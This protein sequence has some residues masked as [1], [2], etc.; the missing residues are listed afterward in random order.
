MENDVSYGEFLKNELAQRHWNQAHLA[1]LIGKS[2]SVIGRIIHEQNKEPDPETCLAIARA[3]E[4]SPV[5]LMRIAKILP[6]EP[7]TIPLDH[8]RE[9]LGQLSSAGQTEVLKMAVAIAEV[10]LDSEKGKLTAGS[11]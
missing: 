1:N 9:A 3:L 10:K 4:M 6:P 7:G 2:R 11:G 5:E 8:F